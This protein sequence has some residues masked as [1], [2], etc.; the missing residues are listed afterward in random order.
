MEL[1]WISCDI[2]LRVISAMRL[3]FSN[4]SIP[5]VPS[6]HVLSANSARV[7]LNPNHDTTGGAKG[8]EDVRDTPVP[9][10]EERV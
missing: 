4:L 6:E 1:L 7:E 8:G 3:L 9:R 2:N 5:I 10:I